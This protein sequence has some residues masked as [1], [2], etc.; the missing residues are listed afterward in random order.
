MAG[1]PQSYQDWERC[2]TVDCGIPL[3]PGFIAERI[4]RLEDRRD[5]QTRKFIEYWG[6]AHY[7]KT[8]GWFQDAQTRVSA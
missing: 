2:I 6:E 4:K 3:T 7:A 5:Y 8:L 1:I